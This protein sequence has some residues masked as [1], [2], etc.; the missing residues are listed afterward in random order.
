MTGESWKSGVTATQFTFRE[1]EAICGETPHGVTT[2]KEIAEPCGL[3][4][5][6]ERWIPA[7]VGM[8]MRRLPRCRSQ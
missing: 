1:S 3:R 6:S 2:N 7:F 5:A 8:T 4:R